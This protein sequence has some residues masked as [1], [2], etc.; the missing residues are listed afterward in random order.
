MESAMSRGKE[1]NM[2]QVRWA[3]WLV[4]LAM[5]LAVCGVRPAAADV[6]SDQAAAILEWPSV[7][8]FDLDSLF[9]VGILSMNGG[10]SE[11]NTVI[12]LSNTSAEPVFVTCFYENA[13][14][15]CT[16]TGEVC[17]VAEQCCDSE[18][19]CGVC[20]PGWNE[21]DF[22]VQI[23][24]RQPLGWLASDGVS[25]FDFTPLKRFGEFAIDGVNNFGIGGSSNAASRI[26]PVPEE[27]FIGSLR[28]IAVDADGI[29]V[30]RNV[31]KGESTLT[32]LVEEFDDDATTAGNGPDFESVISVAKHNAI[33]IQAI[34]GAVNDDNVLVLGGPEPEYNGCPNYLILNHFF[35]GAENPATDDGSFIVSLLTLVPCTQNYLRQIPGATVVQ[36]LVYNEF[37]Q[38][39]STSRPFQCK[40]LILLSNIDTTQNERSIFSAG[41]AGTLTGQTR[42]N[43]LGSGV[44]GVLTEVHIPNNFEEP[45]VPLAEVNI[46]FQ[47]DRED[48]DLIVLP[49]L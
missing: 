45:I 21:T 41:V 6:R 24:P 48:P 31:L 34:E 30:D 20:L 5:A 42:M 26:P 40:Q 22:H 18:F 8:F 27:P 23:T 4:G 12:Q 14:A 49:T 28:C 3:S 16:N 10:G 32:L 11:I 15:H 38:R 39:F 25:G 1:K 29:P 43:P 9:Q 13:N 2:R 17:I 33:G 44:L 19:G 36:Y 35:D 46:H 7:V 37:E 47:G